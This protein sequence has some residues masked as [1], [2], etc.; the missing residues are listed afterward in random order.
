M[1]S[2]GQIVEP[3]RGGRDP[4]VMALE[5]CRNLDRLPSLADLTEGMITGLADIPGV[6]GV[7][8]LVDPEAAGFPEN[9]WNMRGAHCAIFCQGDPDIRWVRVSR[10]WEAGVWRVLKDK[11]LPM[12]VGGEGP[13]DGEKSPW[14]HDQ[15]NI[16]Q[17]WWAAGISLHEEPLLGLLMV[18]ERDIPGDQKNSSAEELQRMTEVME[19]VLVIWAEASA[20][21][22]RLRQVTAET[23]ALG[24]I[25]QLQGR[26]VAMASH[27]FKTPLT[28]ITA[29]SDV[30]LNR[31]TDEQFPQATEFLGVIKQEADRLLR[32]I[33]R[34]LDF[35]RLEFG[36]QLLDLKLLDMEPLVRETLRSLG[37]GIQDKHL[38][39]TVQAQRHLPQVEIDAD[40]IRQVLVNLVGNAV[41]YTPDGGSIVV[42]LS[43][44]AS[45]I[46]IAVCDNGP[47]IPVADIKRIFHEFY[48][49][50]QAQEGTGLGLSIARHIVNLHGG[51]ITVAPRVTGGTEFKFMLPKAA[52]LLEGLPSYLTRH[53]EPER[54]QALVVNLMRLMAELTVSPTAVLILRD[55][56]GGLLPV[57][58]LGLD[59]LLPDPSAW[60]ET[61]SWSRIL[62][63]VQPAIGGA[64]L[65][66]L[67]RGLDWLV[68]SGHSDIPWMMMPVGR[69]GKALGCVI[70][71]RRQGQDDYRYEDKDQVAVLATIVATAL[72]HLED[73]VEKPLAAIRTLTM[74]RRRGIPTATTGAL[75]LVRELASELG[76]GENEINSIQYAAALHDAGMTRL[77]EDILKEEG[78]LSWDQKDEVD[79][80]VSHGLELMAPLIPNRMVEEI[81]RHHHEWLDGSGYPEGLKGA[82]IPM[83]SR[84]LAVIDAWFSLTTDRPYRQGMSPQNALD[85]IEA[86]AGHQFDPR[87]VKLLRHLLMESNGGE[88]VSISN[89]DDYTRE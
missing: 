20:L 66:G 16:T 3:Q 51:Y 65:R 57:C 24:R 67:T 34:I 53:G 2:H 37:P 61:P 18:L 55:G 71:G 83:G 30:L 21:R 1:S 31:V 62:E 77:D 32:M 36:S 4:L 11:T 22:T 28:S 49:A 56:L 14:P 74:V 45:T 88:T 86:H 81:I 26:F 15:L 54:L 87:I 38:K 17:P 76:L 78:K 29:Y 75:R 73:G 33:N 5:S 72:S 63:D 41:K 68:T 19:P 52:D 80:H 12:P 39:V 35:S 50:T 25:N 27:E 58:A 40:L 8:A 9:G 69:R 60:A 6:A 44:E 42:K 43:E 13:L 59:P 85:E 82:A 7:A 79:R 64:S 48:R 70:L 10:T 46:A 47:G 89:H 23:R 84:V